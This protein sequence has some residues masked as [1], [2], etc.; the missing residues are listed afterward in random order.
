MLPRPRPKGEPARPTLA[1]VR[2]GWAWARAFPRRSLALV[3]WLWRTERRGAV[4]GLLVVLAAALV[5]ALLGADGQTI[6]EILAT[7]GLCALVVTVSADHRTSGAVVVTVLSLSLIGTLAGPRWTPEPLAEPMVPSTADTTIGGETTTAAVGSY[8]IET[9]TVTITQADGEQVPALLR[10]PVGVTA[11][12]PGVVFL[13][14]A[15]THDLR[16]FAGQAEALSSAGVT[17][18]VPSKPMEDYSLTSRDYQAMAADY[19]RSVDYLIALNGVDPTRVGLY[20]ESEGAI[21]GAV[22]TADDERIA[23]LVMASAPVVPLREQMALAMDSY[24]RN[25]GVPEPMLVLI[26]R[27]LGSTR[28]PGGGF[29]YADFDSVPYLER[30]TVPVLML[31]GTADASMPLVQGPTTARQALHSGGAALTVRYYDGANHGL[32]LGSSTDGDLAPGV[33]RDL[34]RWVTGLPATAD[35][36]PHV[37][38]AAPS[39]AYWARTPD[40]TRW[41]ASG[42]LMLAAFVV[43][44]GL[45]ALAGLLWAAGQAPRLRDRR[46]LHLPDPIGRWT[47]SLSLSIVAAWVLYLAYIA[48]VVSL[49]TSY[50]TNYLVSYGGWML[51]QVVALGT[52]VLYVRLVQRVWLMRGH[53]RHDREEGGRWLTV[54]AGCV[55]GSALCGTAVLLTALAYWGLFPLLY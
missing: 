45:L 24:M 8:R 39:Q 11:T 26:P 14:G 20:A 33:A 21:P 5:L 13:H 2:S 47:V 46:G 35:A 50:R 23:F 6:W 27:L 30:I 28:V 49:A 7:L 48:E 53:M 17:T 34:A 42:D 54:P 32:K 51:A 12:T 25:V 22:L 19:Q 38:G 16:G 15:G 43:G 4:L 10:R 40:P 52:V 41:Y 18:L 3:S 9:S 31:Y 55:L 37:A 44:F 1:Q 36:A 29:E